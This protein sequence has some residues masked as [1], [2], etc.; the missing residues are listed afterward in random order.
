MKITVRFLI[1]VRKIVGRSHE[2]ITLE[3]GST[4]EDMLERLAERYG[5]RFKEYFYDAK[6]NSK[7]YVQFLVDGKN[8]AGLDGVKTKLHDG[9]QVAIIPPM[10]GG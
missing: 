1:G 8:V 5:H 9:C 10:R 6:G 4:V 2:E 7:D 3:E